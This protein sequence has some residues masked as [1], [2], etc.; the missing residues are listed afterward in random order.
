MVQRVKEEAR[1]LVVGSGPGGSTAAHFLAGLGA[2]TLLLE[3]GREDSPLGY[4]AKV[5]GLTL[6]R[7]RPALCQREDTTKVGDPSTDIYEVLAPGGLSNQWSC[8]VPR[9]SEDDFSDAK[10]AGEEFT[11]PITYADLVP[12]YER[13]EPLLHI[14]GETKDAPQ[15]PAGR[16]RAARTLAADWRPLERAAAD[17]GRAAV[18]MPYA[19]GAGTF[20][21][22]SGTAFNA[23]TRLVKPA[24]HAGRLGVRYDARVVRLEWSAND[25][26]VV[27]A[28]ATDARGG[29]VRIPCGG[30]VLAAGAVNTAQILLESTSSRFPNGLGNEH[31]VLGR[32]LH[33]HP[34]GKIVI[35]LGRPVTTVPAS[36]VTRP[37]LDRSEP[38]Y[39]AAFMQWSGMEVLARTVLAGRPGRS[40]EIGFSVFGTMVPTRDDFV[41]LDASRPKTAGRSALQVALRRPAAATAVLEDARRE[42]VEL[43]ANAGFEPRERVWKIEVP[44]NSVHY[45]GTCRM[46]SSPRFGVVDS[47][48]RVHGVPNVA[49]ADS[50]VFTTTPEKNP[51]LTAMTL[52]ARAAERLAL[53]LGANA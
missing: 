19:Y 35:D 41:A 51:V 48:S 15:L 28:I 20:F 16:V 44:G 37:K 13:V 27:A 47:W 53:D 38:L 34:L 22:P 39:A 45:G 21:T 42:I 26:R 1:V 10:R 5:R 50:A 40:T 12:W 46:H 49:V 9:F 52:A 7:K 32:Y 24:L 11:W 43:F 33:D 31:D 17:K 4:T 25:G 14:A 18:V 30:V 36:Y 23:F 2:N 8:A 3:A 29:E 6:A